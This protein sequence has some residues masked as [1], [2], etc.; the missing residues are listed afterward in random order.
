MTQKTKKTN[1]SFR[2]PTPVFWKID[3]EDETL[4]GAS[5]SL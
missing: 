5:F 4:N 3:Q 1:P 2:N